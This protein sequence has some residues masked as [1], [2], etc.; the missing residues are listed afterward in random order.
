MSIF[1]ERVIAEEVSF[2]NYTIYHLYYYKGNFCN[3]IGL[4]QWHFS[5]I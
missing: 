3:L 1:S 2:K 5:L 4:E